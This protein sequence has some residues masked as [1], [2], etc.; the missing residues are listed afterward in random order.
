MQ[1]LL[2]F[3]EHPASLLFNNLLREKKGSP[4]VLCG[5]FFGEDFSIENYAKYIQVPTPYS[6]QAG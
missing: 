3:D 5:R 1:I 2:K 4:S 6:S